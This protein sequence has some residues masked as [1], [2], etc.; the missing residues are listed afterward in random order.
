[1]PAPQ[2]RIDIENLN[3]KFDILLSAFKKIA[4]SEDHKHEKNKEVYEKA[5]K[6]IESIK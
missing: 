1:M 2:L 3:K 6:E 4:V 5:I